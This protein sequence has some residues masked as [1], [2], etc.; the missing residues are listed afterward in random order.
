MEKAREGRGLRSVGRRGLGGGIGKGKGSSWGRQG[1]R[2]RSAYG[3][4]TVDVEVVLE[5]A[6]AGVWGCGSTT[7]KKVGGLQG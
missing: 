4:P 5:A 2:R 6:V 1:G 7:G 3:Q